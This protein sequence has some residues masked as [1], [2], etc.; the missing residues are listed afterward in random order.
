MIG[1]GPR[2]G[3]DGAHAPRA[4]TVEEPALRG[5][6]PQARTARMRRARSAEPSERSSRP[7][8][9]GNG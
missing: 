6:G 3:P 5:T 2:S 4:A 1:T 7:A 8:P 9:E